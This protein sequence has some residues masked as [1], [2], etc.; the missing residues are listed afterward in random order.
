MLLTRAKNVDIKNFMF[1]DRI[2]F[3]QKMLTRKSPVDYAWANEPCKKGTLLGLLTVK[4]D[5]LSAAKCSQ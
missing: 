1:D 4:D 3:A 2:I 5:Q